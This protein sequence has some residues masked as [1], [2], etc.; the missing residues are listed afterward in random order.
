MENQA[1]PIRIMSISTRYENDRDIVKTATIDSS[2]WLSC[3][4]PSRWNDVPEIYSG[5]LTSIYNQRHKIDLIID[6]HYDIW[7]PVGMTR[8]WHFNVRE[9]E[10]DSEALEAMDEQSRNDLITG[11]I[12]LHIIPFI[13]AEWKIMQTGR[14]IETP[15]LTKSLFYNDATEEFD[16]RLLI[17]MT[18]T[19]TP[20]GITYHVW[21]D[22]PGFFDELY[23]GP[24]HDISCQCC[25][26]A[27]TLSTQDE[28]Q[29]EDGRKGD[30]AAGFDFWKN[31]DSF[32]E[33]TIEMEDD[34]Y[35]EI[36][37]KNIDQ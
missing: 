36:P 15:D 18:R 20:P 9:P 8:S 29:L 3:T 32:N 2:S 16:F 14:H 10:L 27:Y 35:A 6:E 24:L 26:G 4:A 28:K 37:V 25:H 13:S 30:I 11:E 23:H 12:A 1:K 21:V 22:C 5:L 7:Q 31:Q 17:Y 33:N 34:S 19:P